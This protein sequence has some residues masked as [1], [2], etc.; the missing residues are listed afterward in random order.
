MIPE[1]SLVHGWITLPTAEHVFK[2]VHFRRIS[3][4]ELFFAG[5]RVDQ[6][7]LVVGVGGKCKE[8]NEGGFSFSGCVEDGERARKEWIDSHGLG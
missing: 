6:G 4:S 7:N 8:N 3:S 2:D 1:F 5:E